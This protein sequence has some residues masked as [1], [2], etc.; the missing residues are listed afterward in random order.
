MGGGYI[1]LKHL[2]LIDYAEFDSKISYIIFLHD[3]HLACKISTVRTLDL[4]AYKGPQKER[5]LL[6]INPILPS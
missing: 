3:Y 2:Y 5:L 4:K 6:T 1:I